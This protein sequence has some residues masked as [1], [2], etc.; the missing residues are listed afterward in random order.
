MSFSIPD[1]SGRAGS[2]SAGAALLR[3]ETTFFLPAATLEAVDRIEAD[4]VGFL[5]VEEPDGV[6]PIL[7]ISSVGSG[8]RPP[9]GGVGSFLFAPGEALGGT[10]GGGL[11]EDAVEATELRLGRL[12]VGVGVVARSLA[13]LVETAEAL[14][15][16]LF[17]AVAFDSATD[18]RSGPVAV[19][20]LRFDI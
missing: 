12:A 6:L 7:E 18:A 11:T 20:V 19:L 8:G 17:R 14:D 9:P 1:R 15:T 2:S 4:E 10:L 5:S 3:A 16:V 13:L